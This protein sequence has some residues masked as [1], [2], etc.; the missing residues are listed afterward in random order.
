[1]SGQDAQHAE[2]TGQA[3]IE[4]KVP[5]MTDA[6]EDGRNDAAARWDI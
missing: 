3:M 1:M 5:Q 6:A 2:R 4:V